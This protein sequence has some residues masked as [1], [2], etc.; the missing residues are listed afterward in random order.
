MSQRKLV[1]SVWHHNHLAVYIVEDDHKCFIFYGLIIKSEWIGK[2][3]FKTIDLVLNCWWKIEQ[4]QLRL[5]LI[6]L[7]V[8]ENISKD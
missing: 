6:V 2:I 4:H 3:Q 1:N 7:Y 5:L 8:F